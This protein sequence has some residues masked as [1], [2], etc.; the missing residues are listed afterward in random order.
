MVVPWRSE[1][2]SRRRDRRVGL[3]FSFRPARAPDPLVVYV[4]MPV[5]RAPIA[6]AALEM[7][8]IQAQHP[9]R[10]HRQ[11]P[12][13]SA[14]AGLA[15]MKGHCAH[16]MVKAAVTKVALMTTLQRARQT[17]R[18]CSLVI[19]ANYTSMHL[20]LKLRRQP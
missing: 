4:C 16:L 11:S 6:I 2:L 12:E 9:A 18:L 13:A 7:E 3:S 5:R 10:V 14:S 15:P 19:V 1:L 20:E 17:V 8:R